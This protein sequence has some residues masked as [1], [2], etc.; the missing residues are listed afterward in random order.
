MSNLY[1]L[2]GRIAR[3]VICLSGDDQ[4]DR[5]KAIIDTHLH[6]FAR[7]NFDAGFEAGFSTSGEGWNGEY[8]RRD[9][10]NVENYDVVKHNARSRHM[11]ELTGEKIV[12]RPYTWEKK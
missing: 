7:D 1:D 3:A 10:E 12:T 4:L 8:F 6:Q 2:A 5:A 11:N 9:D